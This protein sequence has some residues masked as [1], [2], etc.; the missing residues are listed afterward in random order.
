[1]KIKNGF[2]KIANQVNRE[3][4]LKAHSLTSQAVADIVSGINFNASHPVHQHVMT[5][6]KELCKSKN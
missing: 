2:R 6:C 5:T 1:M 4:K 3:L